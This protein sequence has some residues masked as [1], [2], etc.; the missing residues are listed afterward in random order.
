MRILW[1]E[2]TRPQRYCNDG[3]VIGGW[4]DSL[5]NLVAGMPEIELIVAF[6]G[7]PGETDALVVD[8][9]TYVPMPVSYSFWER[10]SLKWSWGAN[11]NKLL[12]QMEAVVARYRPDLIQVFGTEWPFGLIAERVDTPVVIH[13][14][15][16][17]VPYNNA[18][19]PPGYDCYTM[20][21]SIP[22][23]HVRERLYYDLNLRREASRQRIEERV[24]AAVCNYMGRTEWDKRLSSIMHPGRKY[25]HVEEALRPSFFQMDS[26]AWRVPSGGRIRLMTTG[27]SNF[28]KGPDMLLKTAHIL[29]AS[30]LDF[31][32]LVAG[33]MPALL[34]R[35]VEAHEETSFKE[36]HVVFLGFTNP[37]KLVELLCETTLYVHTAYIENSPNSLCEAQL[38]GVPVVST[39]VG[40]ISSLLENGEEGVLV[41]AND[42]WQ[43]AAAIL[44][45]VGDAERLQAFSEASRKR[46][47]ARHDGNHIADQLL[48]CYRTLIQ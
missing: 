46:A 27:C 7:N 19:Y 11:A 37:E 47:M 14:Q 12:E 45:L 34:K 4:Q 44:D 26:P 48:S 10:Q 2:V 8:G 30:G 28:W 20:K 32:W 9:I 23:W 6:E 1:F 21:A 33:E 36:N 24:W 43:M 22:W 41:P 35:T 18:M 31:E 39:N 42:P 25:Y 13:I 17:I 5:E 38:L 29:S 15:G 3:R 40:G 16:A